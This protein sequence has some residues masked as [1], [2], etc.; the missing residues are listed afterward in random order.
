MI[1]LAPRSLFSRL[2]VVQLTVLVVALL[3]SFAIHMHDRSEALAQ[4]SG[5]QA[6]QR[7]ADIVK[8]LEPLA[9]AERRRIVQVFSAPPLTISLD[10]KPLDA[11]ALESESG[12]RSAIFGAMLSR[13]LG[14]RRPAAVAVREG[15]AM[16]T[17][18]RTG[19]GFVPHHP[20][21]A[22]RPGVHFGAQPGVSFIAQVQLDDGTLVTFDSRQPGQTASWPYRLLASLAVLLAAVL[23][24]SLIAVRWTTH[25]LKVLA[26]AAD[27]LGRNIDRPPLP[28]KGP[29]EVER[30]ARAFNSMQDR[31]RRH[32][33]ERA[34]TLAA[35][36]HDLKTPLNRLRL[37]AELLEDG[38]AKTKI[39]QDVDE[40]ESM[41][42]D[43]LEFM[44]GGESA[45]RP[46]PI[47]VNALLQ[48]LAT[49]ARDTDDTVTVQGAAF[50]P[51]VGRPQALK[52]CVGNLL[53]NAVKHGGSASVLVED[54]QDR[55]IVR[56]RDQGPGIAETEL[57][58]V[59][60]PFYRLEGSRSRDTGGT[61]LGLSI[62]R[63]IAQ[64]HGGTLTVRNLEEGGLE[65]V[66]TLPRGWRSVDPQASP[67]TIDDV[68]SDELPVR[69]EEKRRR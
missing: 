16:A 21:M 9:P 38:E 31:L 30:A 39:S 6:A 55:L 59:F 57:E 8:L 44:R 29:V 65:A 15:V 20:W 68:R 48:S 56:V 10:Q 50:A 35:M 36:S 49:D 66:L 62:A 42:Y 19:P 34:A 51:Y 69:V 28:E 45:E 54:A 58:R 61:G 53:D 25:P 37:R 3:V 12:A 40:M 2:V 46:Q 60:E 22:D 14:D 18:A 26:E 27:E 13:F 17:P 4:A 63:Q 5:M 7:I 43:T 1:E 47:D 64:R 23:V 41:V 52:R 67:E 33:R 11:R 32:V 24:V